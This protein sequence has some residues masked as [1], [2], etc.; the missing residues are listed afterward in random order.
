MKKL[1][2]LLFIP[3][4]NFGQNQD[5]CITKEIVEEN[6][7]YNGCVNYE[8]TPNGKGKFSQSNGLKYDGMF[9]DFK[10]HG[11]GVLTFPDGNVYKGNFV[12]DKRQGQGELTYTN[13]DKYVG[14]FKNDMYWGQG[15]QTLYFDEQTQVRDGFFNDNTFQHG[16][17]TITFNRSGIIDT[18]EYKDFD[19]IKA[20][21][22]E[23]QALVSEQIG[24]F[25]SNGRLKNGSEINYDGNLQTYLEFING[26]EVSRA[27]NIDNRYNEPDIIG[28]DDSI[29]LD[30]Q[31]EGNTKYIN[32]N[33][34]SED[35]PYRF[36]F[37]TGAESFVIGYLLFEEL[38]SKG[39][40]FEDMG[41]KKTTRGVS[42]IPFESKVIKINTI[43]IGSY[44]VKNVYTSV[45][46]IETANSNLL[47][48]SF[49][50]KFRDVKWSLNGDKLI[51]EK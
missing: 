5:D 27:T 34:E 51:F 32:V 41:I 25:F 2:L 42:G 1:I 49:M 9:K 28:S 7:T 19:I 40:A 48:I 8:G 36:V 24:E 39:L 35:E 30:L 45:P 18:Y 14:S 11:Y 4:I 17:E 21:R 26:E 47:G 43:S 23:N 20:V 44:T 6:Y 10:F 3:L 31:V 22:K 37:D 12:E 13:G 38:K 33:F 50:K 16:T 46:L 15:I 29:E